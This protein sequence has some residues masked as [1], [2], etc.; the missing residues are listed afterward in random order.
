META[1]RGRSPW[2]LA[3]APCRGPGCGEPL[4]PR[5]GQKPLGDLFLFLMYLFFLFG[6]CTAWSVGS[7][8]GDQGSQRCPLHCKHSLNYG[9][10]REEVLP[11]RD[12]RCHRGALPK[13]QA[14]ASLGGSLGVGTPTL[15]HRCWGRLSWGDPPGAAERVEPERVEA[16]RS[17]GPAPHMPTSPAPPRTRAACSGPRGSACIMGTRTETR[18]GSEACMRPGR[19]Q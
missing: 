4:C 13:C 8:S 12:F 19:T 9:P 5:P 2:L 7:S 15:W 11:L 17:T 14:S 16:G 1:A 3:G 18:E 6:G 10:P